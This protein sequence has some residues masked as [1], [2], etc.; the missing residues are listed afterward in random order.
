V[1]APFDPDALATLLKFWAAR[2]VAMESAGP[3]ASDE[4]YFQILMDNVAAKGHSPS[5]PENQMAIMQFRALNSERYSAMADANGQFTIKDVAPGQYTL[6]AEQQ[7]YFDIPGRQAIASVVDGK[8]ANYPVPLLAGG[9]ITGRVMNA[10]RKYLPNANVTA[11]R[12]TYM[13]GKIIPQAQSSQP[14]TTV[15]ST[16]CSGYL[17]ETTL[18]LLDPPSYQ[19]PPPGN[20]PATA[21]PRGGAQVPVPL[22]TPQFMRTF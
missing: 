9:T 5:L 16:V 14:P 7:G 21:G 6:E 11:Y 22:A 10:A 20:A 15:A 19:L 2:G 3:R 13:N 18:C 8:A 17:R 4:S 12:I 1:N